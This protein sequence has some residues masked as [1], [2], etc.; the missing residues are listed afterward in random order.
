MITVIGNKPIL[1]WEDRDIGIVG[2]NGVKTLAFY[3][4]R[5]Q[6]ETDLNDFSCWALI[7]RS[8]M[9]GGDTYSTSVS[10]SLQGNKIVVLLPITSNETRDY[11]YI[12]CSLKFATSEEATPVWQTERVLLRISKGIL[13]ETEAEALETNIFDQQVATFQAM[14]DL[15]DLTNYEHTSNKVTSVS[16]DSTDVQYPSAKVLWE[17]TKYFNTNTLNTYLGHLVGAS[18]TTTQFSTGVGSFSLNSLTSG[19][20]NTAVGHSSARANTTGYSNT[21]LG[22]DAMLNN[23]TGYENVSVGAFSLVSGSNV[24]QSTAVGAYSLNKN[25]GICNTALGHSSLRNNTNGAQNLAC[26][27]FSLEANT[28]GQNNVGVGYNA[29]LANT[30]ASNNVAVGMSS[31]SNLASGGNNT[32][33]GTVSGR[34]L[35]NGSTPKDTATECTYLGYNTRSGGADTTNET[36]IGASAIGIG[37]N[38]IVLGNSSVATTVLRG[39]VR[40]G[41]KITDSAGTGAA[42]GITPVV[43]DN[44]TSIPT[45]AWVNTEIAN[46]FANRYYFI[47]EN[48]L[49]IGFETFSNNVDGHENVAI[50]SYS[51]VAISS[52]AGNTSV[53]I[54]SLSQGDGNFAV[55]IGAHSGG[56][57]TDFSDSVFIGVNTNSAG[58]VSDNEIVIGGGATGA[59]SNTAT[60]GNSRI[61]KTVLRGDVQIGTKITASDGTSPAVGITPTAGDNSTKLA[62]TAFVR[63][64]YEQTANKITV[65]SAENTDAQYPSAK[66]VYDKIGHIKT[67]NENTALGISSFISNTTGDG[68]NAIGFEALYSNTTGDYNTASGSASLYCNTTGDYN[69]AIGFCAGLFAGVFNE[70]QTGSNS[71]FIG[72]LSRPNENGQNNQIVIGN[73]AIGN[74]SRTTTIGND[75]T[76]VTYIRG[77]IVPEKLF[78]D[79]VGIE[80]G[81]YF[82]S[83]DKHFYGYNGTTFVQ[84]DN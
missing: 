16:G 15:L 34:Y 5:I 22:R 53:G 48:N 41:T 2:D 24:I 12:Y 75:N 49:G 61:T 69:T 66:S 13:G 73:N 68:N 21:A 38:S 80:G 11:G 60:L 25:S 44:T 42:K 47:N 33:L 45:C 64:E 56:T 83:N 8:P 57:A 65:L 62:T 82:N 37:S 29:L 54:K 18:G 36:V 52:G 6:E 84:L 59:G 7:E 10:K 27:A 70:N 79:P 74:G 77:Q 28:T 3:I 20:S 81:I 39:D 40:V 71:I 72:A 26:G 43:S 23:A 67:S 78:A 30:T 17:R 63:G 32:S 46:G 4:D 58:A 51:Q 14:I 31:L 50:G 35:A 9:N 1:R 19:L 76:L 55:S